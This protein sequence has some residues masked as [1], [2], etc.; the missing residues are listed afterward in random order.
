[1]RFAKDMERHL[2][3]SKARRPSTTIYHVG[4]TKMPAPPV[5]AFPYSNDPVLSTDEN[6]LELPGILGVDV[7]R[8]ET[9]ATV[10]RGPVGVVT[11]DRA[12][13][14]HLDFEAALVVDLV[15][16]DDAS[17]RVLQSPDHA[18]EDGRGYLQAGGILI[19]R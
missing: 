6:V 5:R 11:F 12:E 19:R 18:G 13:V 3:E 4:V 1:M 9:R 7:L 15:G 8:E 14:G 16:F 10:E 2:A 17:L